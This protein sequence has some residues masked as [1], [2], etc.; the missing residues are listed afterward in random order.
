MA[1]LYLSNPEQRCY[2][3]SATREEHVASVYDVVLATEKL[4]ERILSRLRQDSRIPALED[5]VTAA[6]GALDRGYIWS[7]SDLHA[8]LEQ[9]VQVRIHTL[10]IAA[11]IV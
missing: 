2:I 10:S 7:V 8:Q 11:L 9:E 4:K 1:L 6:E 3:L 5:I